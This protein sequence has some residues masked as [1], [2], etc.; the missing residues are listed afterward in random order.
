MNETQRLESLLAGGNGGS[1]TLSRKD[2][3]ELAQKLKVR[4]N[5]GAAARLVEL[6]NSPGDV[7]LDPEEANGLLEQLRESGRRWVFGTNEARELAAMKVPAEPGP[8]AEPEPEPEPVPAPK[9]EPEPEPE[10]VPAPEAEPEPEAEPVPAPEAEPEP[11][12]GLEPEPG[13]EPEPEPEPALEPEPEPAP[14]PQQK[15]G[16][17]SRLF[18]RSDE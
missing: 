18:S 15:R 4:G 7:D 2:A 10:P 9:A 3:Q 1:V 17:F 5:P 6:L 16:F 8:E 13:P 11:E 12:P 14:E